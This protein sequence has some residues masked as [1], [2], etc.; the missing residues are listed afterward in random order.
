MGK[1]TLPYF[2]L[3]NK[4]CRRYPKGNDVR[5]RVKFKHILVDKHNHQLV[6]WQH[7]GQAPG[8]VKKIELGKKETVVH[9]DNKIITHYEQ[10]YHERKK[11]LCWHLLSTKETT[12]ER[13]AF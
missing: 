11:I 1:A 3:K 5:Y 10:K 4:M 12:L 8:K 9:V 2:L 13:A 7:R 6:N